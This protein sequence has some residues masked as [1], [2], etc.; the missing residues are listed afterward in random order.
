MLPK[1]PLA[2]VD[3]NR[4]LW[5]SVA[6]DTSDPE[7]ERAEDTSVITEWAIVEQFCADRLD[8]DY[9]SIVRI[10]FNVWVLVQYTRTALSPFVLNVL[11]V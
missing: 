9:S 3:I 2:M 8:Y 6:V 5:A 4:M 7:G 11:L 1:L 10:R